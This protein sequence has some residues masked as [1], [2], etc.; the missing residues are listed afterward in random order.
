[1]HISGSHDDHL[2]PNS[3]NPFTEAVEAWHVACRK[4]CSENENCLDRYRTAVGALITWL[5]EN[6]AA[7]R[8]YFGDCG[9]AEHPRLMAYSRAAR[10]RLTSSILDLVLSCGEPGYET[11]VEFVVGAVRQ[12]VRE[13]LRGG[14]VDH[15]RLAH[16]LTH[17]APFLSAHRRGERDS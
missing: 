9:E 8:L 14:T 13:E 17:F 2:I 12:L 6:P 3:P 5:S 11:K 1:M 16:R 10:S 4:A 15:A 7:A